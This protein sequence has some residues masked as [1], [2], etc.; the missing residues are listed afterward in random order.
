MKFLTGEMGERKLAESLLDTID[1]AGM[2]EETYMCMRT[3]TSR[4]YWT[5]KVG[6]FAKISL[7]QQFVD[8]LPAGMQIYKPYVQVL[9]GR[10]CNTNTTIAALIL[11]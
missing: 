4:K 8:N 9:S 5:I 7:A 3:S 6:T 10:E 1:Q 11:E 2:I